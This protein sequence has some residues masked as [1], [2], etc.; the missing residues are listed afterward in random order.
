MVPI[1]PD[2]KEFSHLSY[3]FCPLVKWTKWK[4]VER[5]TASIRHHLKTTHTKVRKEL[6]FLKKPKGYETVETTTNQAPSEWEEFSV[7]VFLPNGLLSTIRHNFETIIKE[8][9]ATGGFGKSKEDFRVVGLLKDVKT[10]WS[11]IFLMI[12]R[13]LE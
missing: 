6:V 7:P 11:A 4:N 3:R 1:R 2:K 5:Q 12:D 8:G 9:N 13:L 10:R